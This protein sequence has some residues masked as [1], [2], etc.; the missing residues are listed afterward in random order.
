MR[1]FVAGVVSLGAAAAVAACGSSQGSDTTSDSAAT[2]GTKST[3]AP[4]ADV[5]ALDAKLEAVRKPPVFKAPGP[6][7]DVSSLKGR[8]VWVIPVSSSQEFN[9]IQAAGTKEA[10]ALAGLNVKV[11]TTTGV[12]SQWQQ[13]MQ[14]AITEKAGAIILE[15]PDPKLLV[16]QIRQAKQA[17]IPVIVSRTIDVTD[18]EQTQKEVPGVEFS[19]RGPFS[20]ATRLVADYVIAESDGKAKIAYVSY[21]DMGSAMRPM[22]GAFED[23]IE[24]KCPDCELTVVPTTF[25]DAPTK[26]PQ[27]VQSALQANPDVD[28]VVPAFDAFVPFVQSGLKVS[29]K[30]DKVKM[31]TV[32]GTASVL[33]LVQEDGNPLQMDIGEPIHIL[34]YKSI[35]QAMRLMLGEPAVEQQIDMRLFDRSNVDEAGTPPTATGGYG[36]TSAFVDGFKQLWGVS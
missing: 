17:G 24:A 23:E 18:E 14:R 8:T 10:G 20:E 2:P 4:A 28:W 29:N 12:P 7:I 3:Q 6:A 9:Q 26:T 22:V 35:D 34:G 21:D 30:S 27:A 31:A 11:F 15:G 36:D 5:A 16:P 33:K 32:N 25:A 13:G 1:R 19:N